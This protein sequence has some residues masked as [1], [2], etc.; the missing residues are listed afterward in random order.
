MAMLIPVLGKEWLSGHMKR[1]S[2]AKL[3]EF[4]NII[5]KERLFWLRHM[6]IHSFFGKIQYKTRNK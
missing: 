6:H 3:V 5:L 1:Q 4:N 2:I